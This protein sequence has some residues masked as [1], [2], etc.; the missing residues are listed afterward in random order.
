M[1][2]VG[3]HQHQKNPAFVPALC[4][5]GGEGYAVTGLLNWLV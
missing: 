1:G 2:P 4:L 5:N 3:E